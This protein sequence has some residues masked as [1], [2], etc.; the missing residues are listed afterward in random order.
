MAGLTARPTRGKLEDSTKEK[1]LRPTEYVTAQPSTS[2]RL[3][4]DT[5]P[6]SYY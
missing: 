5:I 1:D 6:I 3:G 4:L 2:N